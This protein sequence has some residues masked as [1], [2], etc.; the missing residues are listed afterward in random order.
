[1]DIYPLG[2]VLSDLVDTQSQTIRQ[3]VPIEGCVC[4]WGGGG[5]GGLHVYVGR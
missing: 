1:M 2:R 5:G 4:V 3:A